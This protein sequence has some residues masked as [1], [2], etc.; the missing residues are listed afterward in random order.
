MLHLT[1]SNLL[2]EQFMVPLIDKMKMVSRLF[3]TSH[4]AWHR[5]LRIM[6]EHKCPRMVVIPK[7]CPTR[8]GSCLNMVQVELWY[9]NYIAE[10]TNKYQ[11]SV[12]LSDM[13]WMQA[14]DLYNLLKV[15]NRVSLHFEIPGLFKLP[16]TC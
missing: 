9:K 14:K 7:E 5:L 8:W 6:K 2:L 16:P 4:L 11:S 3:N 15:I 10:F 12:N 1:V 13:E